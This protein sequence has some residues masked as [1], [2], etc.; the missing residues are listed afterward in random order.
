MKYRFCVKIW[1]KRNYRYSLRKGWKKPSEIEHWIGKKGQGTKSAQIWHHKLCHNAT[2][3]AGTGYSLDVKAIF[4]SIFCI[5]YWKYANNSN[6]KITPSFQLAFEF[7]PSEWLVV[8][9]YQFWWIID[10]KS[11]LFFTNSNIHSLII[12]MNEEI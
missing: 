12:T 6:K 10:V 4:F 3:D 1:K 8:V 9:L 7:F 2:P 5:R 11:E